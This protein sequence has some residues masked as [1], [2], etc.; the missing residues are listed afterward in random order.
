MK[1]AVSNVLTNNIKRK[2]HSRFYQSHL[3]QIFKNIPFVYEIY[4]LKWKFKKM[5]EILRVG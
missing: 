4:K 5:S 2:I 3:N 1:R